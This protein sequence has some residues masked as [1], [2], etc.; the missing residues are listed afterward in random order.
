MQA[1]TLK[2]YV[3]PNKSP[4][5][6]E[7]NIMRTCVIMET[8]MRAES[9]LDEQLHAGSYFYF[10]TNNRY[11]QSS[12]VYM[13][14]I[15]LCLAGFFIPR[16]ITYYKKS[17]YSQKYYETTI[18]FVMSHLIGLIHLVSP[19]IIEKMYSFFTWKEALFRE[20]LPEPIAFSDDT[21]YVGFLYFLFV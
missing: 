17:R 5:A 21:R 9:N 19:R 7:D 2:G 8:I 14:P 1:F 13:Y 10:P 15:G 20:E 6:P 18:F 4:Q 3:K 12:N 11:F 16:V